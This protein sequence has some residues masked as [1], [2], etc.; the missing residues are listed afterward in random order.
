M[1]RDAVLRGAGAT[2]VHPDEGARLP[3]RP[4]RVRLLAPVVA[5]VLLAGLLVVLRLTVAVRVSSG[6][7]LPTL[8]PGDVVLVTP[9]RVDLDRLR[10][11]DLVTFGS[12]QDGQRALKRV[13]ALPGDTVVIKDAVLHVNGRP[14]PEPYVDHELIDAYYSQT[15]TVPSGAVFV[16]GDHRGNSVD[17]RDYGPVAEDALQRRVLLRLWPPGGL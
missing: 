15:H 10:R 9:L 16:L 1:A 8:R 6:S 2:A 4:R 11:G 7:M 12:P 13:V 3:A 17:S 5:A 14:V